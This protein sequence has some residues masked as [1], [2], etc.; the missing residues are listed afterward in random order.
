M[1]ALAPQPPL[2]GT[3]PFRFA[4]FE[5][6]CRL[7][8]GEPT[9]PRHV[10]LKTE[11]SATSAGSITGDEGIPGLSNNKQYQIDKDRITQMLEKCS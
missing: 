11:P 10:T 4:P 6:S 9:S 3:K 5:I 1:G 7:P 8:N 2:T